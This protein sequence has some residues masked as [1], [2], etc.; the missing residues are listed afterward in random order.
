[1]TSS[2]TTLPPVTSVVEVD[3]DLSSYDTTAADILDK[4]ID[5][6]SGDISDV[7][8]TSAMTM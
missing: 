3:G 6:V 7:R 2:V 1:M 5:E 4:F 8:I